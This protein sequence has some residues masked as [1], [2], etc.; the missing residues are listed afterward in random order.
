MELMNVSLSRKTDLAIKALTALSRTDG[1]ITGSTLARTI[2]TTVSFLPQILGPLI[3]AGWVDSERGPGGGYMATAELDDI[4]LLALIEVTEGAIEDG[5][6]VLR[7]GPCPGSESCP[8]H[9]AWLPARSVL[10]D[11]LGRLS[12]SEALVTEEST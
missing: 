7:E 12:L 2:G 4:S 10:I 9:S 8:V 1:R 11:R 5:R 6:C 3:R